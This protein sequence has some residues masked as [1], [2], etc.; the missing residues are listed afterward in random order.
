MSLGIQARRLVDLFRDFSC[1]VP[2]STDLNHHVRVR[3]DTESIQSVHLCLDNHN[4]VCPEG[5]SFSVK[6]SHNIFESKVKTFE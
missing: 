6:Q 3:K 4:S 2:I 1:V 5:I